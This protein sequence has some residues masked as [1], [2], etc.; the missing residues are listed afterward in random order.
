MSSWVHES[1]YLVIIGQE[2]A[3]SNDMAVDHLQIEL[4]PLEADM[5]VCV[6]WPAMMIKLSTSCSQ[7]KVTGLGP[8]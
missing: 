6:Q 7:Q 5:F 1:S 4:L 3:I 8:E 2:S